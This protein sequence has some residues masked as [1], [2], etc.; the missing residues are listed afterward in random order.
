MLLG[1]SYEFW[2]EALQTIAVVITLYF[3]IRYTN[4]TV[5]LKDETIKQ[6]RLTMRPFVVVAYIE[7]ENRYKLVN[8]GEAV[9]LNVRISDVILIQKEGIADMGEGE[10]LS[11]SYLFQKVDLIPPGCAAE[12]KDIKMR[13]NDRL[14]PAESFDLGALLPRS[15]I[16]SFKVV[17][18]YENT[19]NERYETK[20]T[21]GEKAFTF[22][23]MVK[24]S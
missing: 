23:K 24:I 17:I 21:L 3:L 8:Y 13:W 6:T 19:E 1:L 16:R 11:I 2:I 5:Q 20:G 12:V 22:E 7:N 9:A 10:E 18:A 14:Y 15:A 4:A